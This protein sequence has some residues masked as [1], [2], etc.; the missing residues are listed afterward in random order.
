MP[1]GAANAF[2]NPGKFEASF[3]I[4]KTGAAIICFNLAVLADR[5]FT[6]Q[7]SA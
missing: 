4:A 3:L 5:D 6:I 2:K 7:P 1:V